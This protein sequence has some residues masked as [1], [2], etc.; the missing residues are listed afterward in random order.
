MK[1]RK[2]VQ[3]ELPNGAVFYTATSVV[4]TS[5]PALDAGNDIVNTIVLET[6]PQNAAAK[7]GTIGNN[8]G[9]FIYVYD[10]PIFLSKSL[11]E[12]DEKA[13]QM[14]ISLDTIYCIAVDKNTGDILYNPGATNRS[15]VNK[16]LSLK[17]KEGRN[18]EAY[19]FL[20]VYN[21][22]WA[23]DK[24]HTYPSNKL[25]KLGKE[26]ILYLDDRIQSRSGETLVAPGKILESDDAV[27]TLTTLHNGLNW[28]FT[29]IPFRS[30]GNVFCALSGNQRVS[31]TDIYSL[32]MCELLYR[33]GT[34]YIFE[35][36]EPMLLF[37]MF[38][39][40]RMLSRYR[41]NELSEA[42][43]KLLTGENIGVMFGSYQSV[44]EHG[45]GKYIFAD[46]NTYYYSRYDNKVFR[47]PSLSSSVKNIAEAL[48]DVVRYPMHEDLFLA[49]YL[50]IGYQPLNEII[51]STDYPQNVGIVYNYIGNEQVIALNTFNTAIAVRIIQQLEGCGATDIKFILCEPNIS[52]ENLFCEMPP[53]KPAFTVSELNDILH[54]L[55]STTAVQLAAISRCRYTGKM[56]MPTENTLKALAVMFSQH[57]H[58]GGNFL[59]AQVTKPDAYNFYWENNELVCRELP[60]PTTEAQAK[61]MENRGR[62]LYDKLSLY[63]KAG[64]IAV[65]MAVLLTVSEEFDGEIVEATAYSIEQYVDEYCGHARSVVDRLYSYCRLVYGLEPH[66]L[67][68]SLLEDLEESLHNA[69]YYENV[70]ITHQDD[71]L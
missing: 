20:P 35:N 16:W 45:L 68:G 1:M 67:S 42:Y 39:F 60:T 9:D 2:S 33:Y 56:A 70:W 31:E 28:D 13:L 4:N 21:V 50:S 44:A 18:V 65:M 71:A 48:S 5:N 52:K 23:G 27:Y 49:N 12:N 41:S 14:G 43:C 15:S 46:E 59:A 69:V 47:A 37:S 7:I 17:V 30:I 40:G 19:C 55:Y 26:D 62:M 38:Q 8:F 34:I 11:L 29:S 53:K 32:S 58:S 61:E 36:D 22:I 57:G 66:K 25:T 6:N 3:E 10:E 51:L 63:T 54:Y 64:V 24:T